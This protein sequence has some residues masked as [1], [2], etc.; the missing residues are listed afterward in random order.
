MDGIVDPQSQLMP[1]KATS[2]L[3]G[4]Y[5][6]VFV[7]MWACPD[8]SGAASI[9]YGTNLL[10]YRVSE[11]SPRP[12][13]TEVRMNNGS[14]RV[15]SS[16][17][18]GLYG[19]EHMVLGVKQRGPDYDT[20]PFIPNRQYGGGVWYGMLMY[21][22]RMG[23]SGSPK[24]VVSPAC[25]CIPETNAA[26][27]IACNREGGSIACICSRHD[28]GIGSINHTMY[29][30]IKCGACVCFA[31]NANKYD[32]GLK[33]TGTIGKQSTSITLR[34]G[35]TAASIFAIVFK[36][37]SNVTQESISKVSSASPC[38]FPFV[39]SDPYDADKNSEIRIFLEQ[40]KPNTITA[41]RQSPRM[42]RMYLRSLCGDII[43]VDRPCLIELWK[44]TAGLIECG[45]N[46]R[47]CT[48]TLIPQF[49]NATTGGGQDDTTE[50]L[51]ILTTRSSMIASERIGT[52]EYQKESRRHCVFSAYAHA[53]GASTVSGLSRR[54]M[55][56]Q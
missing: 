36:T 38:V 14:E 31:M 50:R 25:F 30:E 45:N 19:R 11:A 34:I 39:V 22:T 46:G 8:L 49:E 6:L 55:L 5:G 40:W 28:E 33:P 1:C 12:T 44:L 29:I 42:Q 48:P 26:E 52:I 41:N 37:P 23:I 18:A 53:L 7:F 35:S 20:P 27:G 3:Y 13:N 43:L 9:P 24:S 10:T 21:V 16:P 54:D 4:M 51:A 47:S 2:F 56:V 32:E 17:Q 15:H